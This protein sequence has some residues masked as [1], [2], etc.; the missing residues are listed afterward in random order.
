V[1]TYKVRGEFHDTELLVFLTRAGQIADTD[2]ST[3]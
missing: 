1:L 2:L 3:E